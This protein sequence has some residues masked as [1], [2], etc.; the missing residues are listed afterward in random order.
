MSADPFRAEI[1]GFVRVLQFGIEQPT[2]AQVVYYSKSED[3]W[4]GVA[5]AN[6]RAAKALRRALA[7]HP[8]PD[9]D[10]GLRE[11]VWRVGFRDGYLAA[12]GGHGPSEYEVAAEWEEN[13]DRVL[14]A[15]P[16]P[17]GRVEE[18]E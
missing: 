15:H 8:A 17:D 14:A 10:G 18:V 13:R 6:G 4:R 5:Y 16:A 1:E 9:G 12:S 11:S 7:A 2:A 3:F